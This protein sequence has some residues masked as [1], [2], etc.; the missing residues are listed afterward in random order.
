[1]KIRIGTKVY[2]ISTINYDICV[3]EVGYVGRDSFIIDC[4]LF[5]DDDYIECYYD[6]YNE[7][8]FKSLAAAKKYLLNYF[9]EHEY[10]GYTKYK[11]TKVND[12]Y[13]KIEYE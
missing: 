5:K 2:I 4:Y 8:W 3:E 13:Y 10:D 6:E 7:T 1:M 9:K 11:F 12:D